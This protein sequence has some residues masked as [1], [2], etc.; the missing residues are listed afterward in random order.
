M[1]ALAGAGFR[2]VAPDLR[3]YGDSPKPKGAENYRVA[4]LVEDVAR[5][6]ESMLP[7]REKDEGGRMKDGDARCVLV[8][9]DWG[10]A[11]AWSLAMM[12][13]E[14]VRRLAILNV[15][16]PAAIARE[17]KRNAKQ[18]VRL[19]YQLFFQLPVLPEIFMRLFGRML[20]RRA[21]RFTEDEIETYA[22]QWRAGSLTPMLDYY[23]AM[24]GGARAEMRKHFRRIEVP[25]LIIWAEHE[26]VF[27][28]S[29][30]EDLDAFV[31]DVRIERIPNAGHYVARD[32]PEHVS[33]LLIGF[34][35]G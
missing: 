34:A 27:L 23:R 16:H 8:G 33:E 2:V 26:P 10:A 32:A 9:H 25:V 30:L 5:L 29:A 18:K 14:L 17:L 22:K 31:A 1:P 24:R 20:L 6:I 7:D 12:R 15:P 19:L 21:G 3:G 13:P 11:V 28:D 4:L 35:R